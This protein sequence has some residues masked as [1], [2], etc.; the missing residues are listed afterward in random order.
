MKGKLIVGNAPIA[1]ADHAAAE[2]VSQPT[3]AAQP[4]P[5]GLTRLPQPQVAPPIER[6]E[7]ELV[8]VDLETREV[9]AL[10]DDGVAYRYW[11]FNGS[12]P[13]PMVRVRQGD[14]VELTLK[15]A[16]GT[17]LT[18]SI[19][20]HAVNGP[21]GGSVDTQVVPG[22]SSTIRFQALH[23]GVYVYHCMTPMVSPKAARSS[24]CHW[25][26]R[27]MVGVTTNAGRSAL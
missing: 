10:L 22:D 9:T 14:T 1:H 3:A 27:S 23:P 2:T 15:N 26:R 12:I 18:H 24:S 17:Q 20:L 25:L 19:N 6:R 7:P 16:P 21:G 4:L 8:K 5:E 11:T 13:G